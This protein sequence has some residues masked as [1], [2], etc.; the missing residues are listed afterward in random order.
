MKRNVLIG[1]IVLVIALAIAAV[2]GLALIGFWVYLVWMVRKKRIEIF[3]DRMEPELAEKRYKRLKLLLLVAGI[4]LV[5]GIAGVI[6]YNVLYGV[7]DIEEPVSF[8]FG[9]VGLLL[10][11][12]ATIGSLAVFVI[13]RRKSIESNTE[14]ST[15]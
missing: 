14:T 15:T 7:S 4:A 13:G 2:V 5:V 1:L 12:F 6:V 3:P 11:V 10:F 8:I 9:F